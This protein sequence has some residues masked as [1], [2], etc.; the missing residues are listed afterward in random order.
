[1]KKTVELEAGFPPVPPS[2][3]VYI[4]ANDTKTPDSSQRSPSV[5]SSTKQPWLQH[6]VF[7]VCISC[8]SAGLGVATFYGAHAPE[9]AVFETQL[10]SC[11]DQIHN[12]VHAGIGQ[13]FAASRMMQH[14]FGYA[15]KFGR[16]LTLNLSLF[17]LLP[18]PTFQ[19]YIT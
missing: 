2:T 3:K 10:N 16:Y 1:M 9:F 6:G 14:L 17:C 19:R 13:T 4:S 7:L 15:A 12:T 11:F 8:L 18:L 5:S